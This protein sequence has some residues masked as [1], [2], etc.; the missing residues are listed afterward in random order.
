MPMARPQSLYSQL[1]E[2]DGEQT[3]LEFSL[4]CSQTLSRR[5]FWWQTVPSS[6]RSDEEFNDE[7][8]F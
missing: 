8:R 3:S 2:R 4:N 7:N 5:Q 1:W 6:C